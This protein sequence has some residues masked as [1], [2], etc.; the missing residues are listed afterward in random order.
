MA[1]RV[2][3]PEFVGRVRELGVLEDALARAAAGTTA[4][5]LVGGP[6]GVGKS[7]LLAQFEHALAGRE[8]TLLRGDC[9]A[10]GGGELPYAPISA[11]LRPLVLE[12]D[13]AAVA[14][15]VGPWKG[16][17]ARL[18][19]DLGS[20]EGADGASRAATGEPVERAR[21]FHAVLSMLGVAARRSGPLVL[22]VEDLHWADQSTLELLSFLIRNAR[23][24][25]L[26]IVGTYRSDELHR[27][28]PLRPF[29]LEE[30][31]RPSVERVDV[32]PFTRAELASQL[33]G[34]LGAAPDPEV[35]ERLFERSEGNAF[36][37]EELIAASPQ[38][39]MPLPQTLRDALSARLDAL[40]EHALPALRVLAVAGRSASHRLLAEAADL[41]EDELGASLREA[42]AH[43]LIVQGRDGESYLF[44]HALFQEAVYADL[45]PGER[46]TLHVRLAEAL[47][48]DASLAD[49]RGRTAKA[50][51]AHHWRSAHR[52]SEAVASSIEAAVESEGVYAFAEARRHF[53]NALELWSQVDDVEAVAGMTEAQVVSR[54]AEASYLSD[55]YSRAIALARRAVELADES[56]R[57]ISSALT[58]ERL[59]RYLWVAGDSEAAMKMTQEAVERLPEDEP[60]PESALVLA[61]HAQVLMLRGHPT[62]RELCERAVALARQ[63]GV[64]RVEGHALNSLGTTMSFTGER[65]QGQEHLREGMRIARELE[66]WDDLGRSYVNLSDSID[67]DGRTAEAVEL[68]LEGARMAA[69]VGF[70][71]YSQFLHAEALERLVNLGRLDQG[72]ALMLTSLEIP[73]DGLTG[74]GLYGGAARVLL[75]RGK[76]DEAAEMV[77]NANRVSLGEPDQ[78]FTGQLTAIAAEVELAK[79][80]PEAA[81]ELI[82]REA[83]RIE[84]IDYAFFVVRPLALGV[85]AEADIAER[86]RALGDD[87]ALQEAL[88]RAEELVGLLAGQADPKAWKGIPP[89]RLN[90]HALVAAAELARARGEPTVDAYVAAAAA[91]DELEFALEAAQ[92]RLRAAEAAVSAGDRERAAALLAESEATAQELGAG[93]LLERIEALARR[94]RLA[95]GATPPPDADAAPLG[96]TERELGVLELVAA[97]KT[98]RE[99]GEQLF[100]SEKT[101]SVHVSRILSKLSVKSRVEA[102]TA[103]HRMG[104]AGED[105]QSAG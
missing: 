29:L 60:T 65:R 7:R 4:T 63:L 24:E 57:A 26:L 82:R 67:Q 55:D 30:E 47:S 31:R 81:R 76:V 68:A 32:D 10:L 28:H 21:L 34:I 45:L 40:P 74:V 75:A 88:G 66:H 44:R 86:A 35:V 48:A 93:L 100:I 102:A 25:P 97:G 99:I 6:S 20:V 3:S 58:R 38:K 5:V 92:A 85:E 104:L 8:A 91:F 69:A 53:E 105:G 43:Q 2:T 70:R 27:R 49:P 33:E 22:I 101:A 72:E 13:D 89:P 54:A 15:I 12:G 39:G 19:P 52:L 1:Q 77:A 11:A 18:L 95:V 94:A 61:S 46:T 51:L 37:T 9:F 90:A 80:N 14:E 50:E 96:L 17:L 59:G 41:S 42:E 16:A 78:M 103:A 64:R 84:D 73:A 79:R 87:A 56:D 83:E 98:N 71:T 36:Y 62:A 23:V